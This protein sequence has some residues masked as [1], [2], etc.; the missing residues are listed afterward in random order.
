MLWSVR[1]DLLR[2]SNLIWNLKLNFVYKTTSRRWYFERNDEE[3]DFVFWERD[4]LVLWTEKKMYK[5]KIE[6]LNRKWSWKCFLN[7]NFTSRRNVD[8]YKSVLKWFCIDSELI[9]KWSKNSLASKAWSG[10]LK[11]LNTKD[12]I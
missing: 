3:E 6:K 2:G 8:F 1:G 11:G 5:F 9:L 12:Q 4:F 10:H 7:K